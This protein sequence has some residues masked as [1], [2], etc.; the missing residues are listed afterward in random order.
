MSHEVFRY[1]AGELHC[2]DRVISEISGAVPTP[3]YVYSSASLVGRYRGLDR[4]LSG[5]SHLICF[6]LKANSQPELL[7]YLVEEGAGAEAVSGAEL[8]LALR[9]G[10]DP[11]LPRR[12]SRKQ[13]GDLSG[14]G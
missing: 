8:A 5:V 4:A 3:F 10:F 6:A 13:R 9:V 2:E 12:N 11:R 7:R 14:V 1:R